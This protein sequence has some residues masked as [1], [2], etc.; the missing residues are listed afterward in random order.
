M[1]YLEILVLLLAPA[2][3]QDVVYL[4]PCLA[5][6]GFLAAHTDDAPKAFAAMT[7]MN[8]QARINWA[9]D[10]MG[11]KK[12][13]AIQLRAAGLTVYLAQSEIRSRLVQAAKNAEQQH[14]SDIAAMESLRVQI[15]TAND[16]A[17]YRAMATPPAP[18]YVAPAPAPV[19]YQP[20]Y[21]PDYTPPAQ[22]TRCVASS[23]PLGTSTITSVNC[24]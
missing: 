24:Y 4:D 12:A 3:A 23:S 21:I 20:I 22:P 17:Y 2:M 7:T 9:V 6:D 14:A 19:Q 15:K 8:L 16:N 11:Q 13:T 1:K 10:C 18:V 5:T